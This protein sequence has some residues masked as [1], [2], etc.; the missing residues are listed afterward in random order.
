MKTI[1]TKDVANKKIDVAREFAAPIEK[2]WKAWTDHKLLDQ[3]WAPK[4]WRAETK[5]MDFKEGGHW[6]YSMVGPAGERHW[7]RADY[8][9]ISALNYFLMQ[10]A[11]CDEN[12]KMNPDGSSGDWKVEFSTTSTGTKVEIHITF[13]SEKHLQM[14]VEM[15]FQQGFTMAMDNLDGLI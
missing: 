2:T 3:W 4:P 9:K 15:G 6:L 14:M 7:S 10:Q 8:K 1:F 5:T 11:F 13:S 12:G